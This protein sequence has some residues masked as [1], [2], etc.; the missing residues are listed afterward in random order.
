MFP[1]PG[2][3]RLWESVHLGSSDGL[4][5]QCSA[6]PVVDM[7]LLWARWER[8]LSRPMAAWRH[9]SLPASG[10]AATP[11]GPVHAQFQALS[12]RVLVL[13]LLPSG[14]GV[15]RGERVGA[16]EGRLMRR[17]VGARANLGRELR[18]C[19]HT[20]DMYSVLE[21]A[22]SPFSR[23]LPR[24]PPGKNTG[25]Y[26]A[27]AAPQVA[28]LSPCGTAI[29]RPPVARGDEDDVDDGDDGGG[30]GGGGGDGDR[31]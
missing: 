14:S 20:P 16:E 12:W 27:S 26:S 18:S 19:V 4:S 7:A 6:P 31:S 30:G 5:V 8:N 2:L 15:D 11:V 3:D 1:R 21:M 23:P 10:N 24:G 29:T 9:P 25:K 22:G 13:R 28:L 17:V